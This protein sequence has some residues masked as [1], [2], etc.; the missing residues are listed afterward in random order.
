MICFFCESET[1]NMCMDCNIVGI[2]GE[3]HRDIHR[4]IGKCLPFLV[5]KSAN[6]GRMVVASRDIKCG[7]T[8]LVD[9]PCLIGYTSQDIFENIKLTGEAIMEILDVIKEDESQGELFLNLSDHLEARRQELVWSEVT[10]YIVPWV[11]SQPG[12]EMVSSKIIERIVGII[13]TNSIKW[14][15]GG[16]QSGGYAVCPVFAMINHSCVS[17]AVDVET[18]DGRMEVRA[19]MDIQE[20]EEISIQYRSGMVLQ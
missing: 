5:R 17:N 8:L 11:T 3:K 14:S 1:S 10:D 15:R 2:C 19:V 13:R 7:E 18:E 20:G 12:R 16:R 4:H 9:K 6:K